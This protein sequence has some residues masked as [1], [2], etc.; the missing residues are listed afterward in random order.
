MTQISR[1]QFVYLML[2]LILGTGIVL[3]PF[4][5]AQFTI[6][7]G[8]IVPVFFF[9]GTAFAAGVSVLFIRT[10]PNQTLMNGLE[11]A[12]GSWIGRLFG[13]WL[14][15]WF[16]IASSM[17]LRELSVFVENTAL[18]KTPLYIISATIIIPIAYGVFQ[19]LE[20]LGRL[21][22]FLTP[23]AMILAFSLALVSLQNVDF[24]HLRPVLANGWTPVLRA[25]V[26]PATS[27]PFEFIF[28]LQFVKALRGGKTFGRDLMLVGGFLSVAGMLIEGIVISVLG[29]AVTYLPIPVG[30]VVRGVRI[31]QFVE[32]LDTIYA[33]GVIATMAVKIS[34]FLYAMISSLQ[35]VF[36]L[37]TTK[38][39]TWPAGVAVWAANVVFFHNAPE[40]Q[41]FMVYTTPAYFGFSLVVLPLVAISVYRIK[42][43]V[44]VKP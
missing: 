2:W 28:A 41:E 40:L 31:G 22:E 8:W 42:R 21:A 34:V 32:R 24:S 17:L 25:A 23:I 35:D 13:I 39:V 12:F 3:L 11:T 15:V 16:L 43:T 20:V 29:P 37:P 38:N 26:L 18:P 33:M 27:F 9:M 4:A 7:D 36:R 44:G 30:E 14:I 6:R 10:F 19:G 1:L 5:I